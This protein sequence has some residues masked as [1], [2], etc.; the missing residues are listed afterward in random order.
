MC[1]KKGMKI[2]I[3][4]QTKVQMDRKTHSLTGDRQQMVKRFY[5]SS[6][7]RPARDVTITISGQQVTAM[8]NEK[9]QYVPSWKLL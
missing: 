1:L 4:L 9:R 5:F 3:T 6:Q 7:L 8:L 2:K